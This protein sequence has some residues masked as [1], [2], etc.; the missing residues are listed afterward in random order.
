MI[1]FGLGV[2]MEKIMRKRKETKEETLVPRKGRRGFVF[3]L[4]LRTYSLLLMHFMARHTITSRES[5][6]PYTV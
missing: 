2:K 3:E 4:I 6:P 1:A 5:L